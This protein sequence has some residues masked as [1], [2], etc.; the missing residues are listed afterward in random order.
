MFGDTHIP[1]AFR[2]ISTTLV[3]LGTLIPPSVIH[4]QPTEGLQPCAAKHTHKPLSRVVVRPSH[5]FLSVTIQC[6]S[7]YLML[8]DVG[9]PEGMW[10]GQQLKTIATWTKVCG[11]VDR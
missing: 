8:I 2:N 1:V 5:H 6:R 3:I 11:P 10:E 7:Q 9:M 4:L